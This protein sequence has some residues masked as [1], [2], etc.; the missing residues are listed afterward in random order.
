MCKDIFISHAWGIDSDNRDNH[1]RAKI[2]CDKLKEL[3][4]TTWFDDYDMRGNID[5]CII[6]GINNAKVVIICLT[7]KYCNKINTAVHGQILNDNCYKEWNY[8]LFKQKFIIPIIMEPQMKD[9]YLKN[10]G[11][12]QMYFNSTLYI[13]ASED[14][15]S[16]VKK[17]I[18]RAHV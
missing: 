1:K 6:N 11:I 18:G 14:L 17:K 5:S 13:D 9:I 8:S 16:A 7:E 2:I 12:V 10:D 15:D 3:E 4:Y